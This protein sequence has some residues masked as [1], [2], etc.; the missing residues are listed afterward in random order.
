MCC[1]LA[2]VIKIDG[3]EVTLKHTSPLARVQDAEELMAIQRLFE[4]GNATVGPEVMAMSVR[5]E[6]IPEEIVKRVGAPRSIMRD[7]AEK[8]QIQQAAMAAAQQQ[9][10]PE[11]AAA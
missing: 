9:M 11:T 7:D 10:E 6:N 8:E 5:I 2:P 4:M 3:R 1:S